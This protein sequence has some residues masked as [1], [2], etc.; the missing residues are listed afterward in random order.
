MGGPLRRPDRRP[1]NR[2]RLAPAPRRPL[3]GR[4]EAGRL[5]AGHADALALGLALQPALEALLLEDPLRP[6]G[7]LDEIRQVLQPERLRRLRGA[8]GGLVDS[9]DRDAEVLAAFFA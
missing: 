3:A 5:S 9:R 6:L 8:V 2:V 7:Q 1:A 4:P